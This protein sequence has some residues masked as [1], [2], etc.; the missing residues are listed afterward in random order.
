MADELENIAADE[1]IGLARDSAVLL[2]VRDGWEWDAG[3][4][5]GALHIPLTEL[6]ERA[7]EL[8][9]DA[10]ILV[11]CHSGYRSQVA[12]AA[13][14][15]AGFTVMN[16]VGGMMAWEGAGGPVERTAPSEPLS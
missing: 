2:D 5:P 6:E 10:T 7:H 15:S 14:H 16:V 8:S 3:H 12:A 1:A 13:L 4:A 9:L 11:I